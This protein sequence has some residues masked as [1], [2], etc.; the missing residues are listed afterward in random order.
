MLKR[1]GEVQF[2]SI[3][4]IYLPLRITW[5]EAK[6]KKAKKLFSL[7]WQV[8]LCYVYTRRYRKSSLNS[9]LGWGYIF[10]ALLREGGGGGCLWERLGLFESGPYFINCETHYRYQRRGRNGQ[11]Y[12]YLLP[13]VDQVN[14]C[15]IWRLSGKVH[16]NGP[17]TVTKTA[18]KQIDLAA[19]LYSSSA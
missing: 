4:F 10:K 15:L 16:E 11:G 7:S 1:G 13:S 12:A 14:G 6:K 8:N 5:I 2:N 19:F 3:Q 18:P 9:P 17:N